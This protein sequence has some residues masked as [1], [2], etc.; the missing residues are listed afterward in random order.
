MSYEPEIVPLKPHR[1]RT[2]KNHMAD[3]VSPQT[4][5]GSCATT[6]SADICI[7]DRMNM[8]TTMLTPY[9]LCFATKAAKQDKNLSLYAIQTLQVGQAVTNIDVYW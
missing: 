8:N 5:G 3:T 6:S 4:S 7:T 2:A 1:F 9:D